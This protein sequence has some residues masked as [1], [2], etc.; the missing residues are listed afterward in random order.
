MLR[1]VELPDAKTWFDMASSAQSKLH[2]VWPEGRFLQNSLEANFVGQCRPAVG[3]LCGPLVVVAQEQGWTIEIQITAVDSSVCCRLCSNSLSSG[4]YETRAPH[5][6]STPQRKQLIRMRNHSR[7]ICQGRRNTLALSSGCTCPC[8]RLSR[9]PQSL[10]STNGC[11]PQQSC[12]GRAV[13]QRSDVVV[14][15]RM[16]LSAAVL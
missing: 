1:R 9:S 10:L 12:T 4:Y 16:C 7:V 11:P 2:S 6:R 15:R 13:E 14:R 8:G 5:Q 3:F